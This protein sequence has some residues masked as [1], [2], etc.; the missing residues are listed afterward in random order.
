MTEGRGN[1]CH[2]GK[3]PFD[4]VPVEVHRISGEGDQIESLTH[5]QPIDVVYSLLGHEIAHMEV[6]QMADAQSVQL[7]T[8]AGNRDFETSNHDL[9]LEVSTQQSSTQQP[10]RRKGKQSV[11]KLGPSILSTG[12]GFT[13]RRELPC[14]KRGA[15]N[16]SWPL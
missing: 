9:V 5:Q 3:E 16:E 7:R 15:K 8:P 4:S 6:T 14:P 10:V 11:A 2:P 12:S 1:S 13:H